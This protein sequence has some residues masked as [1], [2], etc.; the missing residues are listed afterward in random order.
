MLMAIPGISD[1]KETKLLL[2]KLL[3]SKDEVYKFAVAASGPREGRL[4]LDKKQ[5]LKKDQIRAG[6]E[7]EAKKDSDPKD[8]GGGKPAK[9]EVI[10]GE[11]HLDATNEATLRIVE[12]V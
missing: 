1:E 8:K 4:I 10:T 7:E 5:K 2:K 3:S 9:L 12:A 6:L 11:C